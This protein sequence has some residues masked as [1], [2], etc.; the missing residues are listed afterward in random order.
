MMPPVRA[1]LLQRALAVFVLLALFLAGFLWA[2][3]VLLPRPVEDVYLDS[4]RLA[5]LRTFER[6]IVPMDAA[7]DDAGPRAE[8]IRSQFEFCADPLKDR[9]TVSARAK[10]TN[11]CASPSAVE[12]LACYVRTINSR[13][14][15]MGGDGRTNRERAPRGRYVV[16]IERWV[17]AIQDP[18]QP[19]ACRAAMAAARHLASGEGKL[20]DL[21][22]WRDLSPKNVVASQFA[23]DQAVKVAGRILEQR[24]PWGG[25]PGCIY[26][27][28]LGRNGKM[29]FVTDKQ[30][31]N[32]PACIAMRP[33]GTN[34]KDLEGAR[35]PPES[36][37]VILADLDNI[38]LPWRDLFRAYTEKPAAGTTL[39]RRVNADAAPVA[40]AHGPN[41]LERAKHEVDAGFNIHLTIDPDAQR[42]VQQASACYAGDPASCERIGL[43][44]DAKF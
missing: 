2:G 5:A 1:S 13:L 42:I 26:Y 20:L 16:S 21:L 44:N 23:P 7:H 15:E 12:E 41:R 37:D 34:E 33:H 30:Q 17:E 38:R 28:H 4:Q 35:T 9:K 29:L 18:Q 43:V 11:A 3:Q 19:V 36:L 22:A 27:G 6:A 8:L 39:I 32:R 40:V 31:S 25:V 24:N 14:G 10:R